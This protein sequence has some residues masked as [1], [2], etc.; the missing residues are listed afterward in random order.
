MLEAERAFQDL[1]R[2]LTTTPL[3]QL[4]DFN[5]SFIIECDVSRTGFGAVLH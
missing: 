1:K 3:L 4:P 5:K 2:A